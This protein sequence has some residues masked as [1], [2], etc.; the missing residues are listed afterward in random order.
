MPPGKLIEDT[1]ELLGARISSGA[2][3]DIVKKELLIAP[4]R[5]RI[6]L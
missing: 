1:A 4:G 2:A 5:G 3:T 6:W